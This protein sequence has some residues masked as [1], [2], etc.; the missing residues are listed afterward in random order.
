[1]NWEEI[2]VTLLQGQLA[3]ETSDS[4]GNNEKG[5]WEGK[6]FENKNINLNVS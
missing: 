3:K 2:Y 1:M 5:F 4:L 6:K